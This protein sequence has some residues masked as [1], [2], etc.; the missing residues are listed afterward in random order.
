MILYNIFVEIDII[1][2]VI[3]LDFFIDTFIIVLYET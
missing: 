2:I 1:F 3:N